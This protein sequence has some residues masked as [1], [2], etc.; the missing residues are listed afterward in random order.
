MRNDKYT[1]SAGLTGCTTKADP[2]SISGR[3]TGNGSVESL[4]CCQSRHPH[5]HPKQYTEAE[6]K[7]IRDYAPPESRPLFGETVAPYEA[8]GLYLPTREAILCHAQTGHASTGEEEKRF[9]S[10]RHTSR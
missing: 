4:V 5:S 3:P 9:I 7:L 1:M 8:V 10:L 2:T 6:M